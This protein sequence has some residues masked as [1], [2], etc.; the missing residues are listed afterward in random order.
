MWVRAKGR[1]WGCGS[2][3]GRPDSGGRGDGMLTLTG[4]GQPLGGEALAWAG[5]SL[6]RADMGREQRDR[7]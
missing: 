4:K 7:V 6:L 5:G 2:G 3:V 1:T